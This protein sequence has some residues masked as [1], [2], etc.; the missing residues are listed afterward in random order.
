MAKTLYVCRTCGY[1]F[2]DELGKLIDKRVQVFCEMCGTPFSLAGVEFT[3]PEIKS[4]RKPSPPKTPDKG[5]KEAKS[6]LS[7]AIKVFNTFAY[8]PVLIFSGVLL[9]MLFRIFF[10]PVNWVTILSNHLLISIAGILIVIYDIKVISPKIKEEKYEDIILDSFCYGIVGCV[11]Y[12]TGVIILIKGILII[13]AAGIDFKRDKNKA[14]EFGLVLHRSLNRFSAKAGFIILLIALFGIVSGVFIP[15][16]IDSFV[17]FIMAQIGST[18]AWLRSLLTIGMGIAFLFLPIILLLIDLSWS[19]TL[20]DKRV[21]S[22]GD[23]FKVF[24][25]GAIC[26]AFLGIGIFILFKGILLFILF[27]GKPID[28]EKEPFKETEKE[29]EQIQPETPNLEEKPLEKIP[30]K[31]IIE[32][33]EEE[34]KALQ[35]EE[36]APVGMTVEI[37]AEPVKEEEK[38][39]DETVA[40]EEKEADTR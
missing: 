32:I 13:I 38:A 34:A 37:K 31:K 29:I 30:E 39:S 33:E 17:S 16:F 14:Y 5:I 36:P 35:P 23:F 15:Y 11:I 24:L 6:S 3:Q 28:A 20:G 25:I 40:E 12:G 10:D 26:T 9:G 8:V 7:K 21:F 2:P 22:F 4:Q 19:K 1:V 27:V 18:E